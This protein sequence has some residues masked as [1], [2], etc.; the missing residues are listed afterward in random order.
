MAL[1]LSLTKDTDSAS[2]LSLDLRKQ[3]PFRV[4]LS[5]E[6]SSDLDLHAFH[7]VNTSGKAT[8]SSFDD[9]LSTYNVRRKVRGQEVGHL[10]K[11]ADGSFQIH[12]GALRHSPDA[13]DGDRAEIDE[14]ITVDTS[15]LNPPAGGHIEIPLIAM[16][17][18]QSGAKK[19]KDVFKPEIV[20]T[21]DDGRELLRVNLS[22][23]FG[24]F[25]GVQLGAI[26][27]SQTDVQFASIGVGFVQDFNE[28][29]SYFC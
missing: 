23:E 7:C 21:G 10:Q 5:W 25:V 15:L 24:E 17:H 6:G 14:Y 27:V 4:T 18:P 2:K 8:V 3:E 9:V 12:G 22:T 11:S 20:I 16:I 28:V 19:F 29:L 1:T 13:T 26:L